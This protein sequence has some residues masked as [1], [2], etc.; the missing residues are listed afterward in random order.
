MYLPIKSISKTQQLGTCEIV[1]EM[2]NQNLTQGFFVN[3]YGVFAKLNNEAEI[4]YA[5]R[6]TGSN[7]QF[8]PA[9]N[10]VDAIDVLLSLI[11]I[12]S[13][14]PNV[15]AIIN[16][17]NTYITLPVLEGRF[18]SLFS[19][20]LA[21]NGFWTWHVENENVLR[22]QTLD[23]V[24]RVILGTNNITDI[25]AR[26]ERLEDNVAEILLS[27][28]MQ[29]LYPGY[30]HYIIE[31]FKNINQIDLFEANIIDIFKGDDL[32]ICNNIE[33]LIPGS[34]YLISDGLKSE[35]VQIHSVKCE[36]GVHK[37]ILENVIANSY[38]PADTK[39]YRTTCE[40]DYNSASLPGAKKS[41]SWIPNF[42]WHG[43]N[44]IQDYELMLKSDTTNFDKFNFT[45]Q[46]NL[47]NEG[48]IT[49]GGV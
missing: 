15:T 18:A 12:I 9:Y 23:E 7:L 2:N 20:P 34:W 10:G 1:L 42:I 11:I 21:I 45:G 28:E 5:Y 17:E 46:I 48:Y 33:G 39:I 41:L 43:R 44:S 22:P 36:N 13:Q 24:K 25:I 35:Y 16:V 3:E 49:L 30:S 19:G 27:L 32:I 31:D 40:L 38:N 6:N 37:I 8:L 29:E 14:A 47:D 4:L 26:L